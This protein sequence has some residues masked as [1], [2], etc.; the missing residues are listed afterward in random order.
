MVR[1]L[2]R[3]SQIPLVTMISYSLVCRVGV[4]EYIR[5]ASGAGVD[6]VIVPDLPV[7]E[8]GEVIREA[9]AKDLCTIFLAAPTT[10]PS[11]ARLVVENSTGFIYY[12]SVLGTTGIR[13]RLPGDLRQKI[14]ALKSQAAAVGRVA[15]GVIVGSAIVKK[16]SECAGRPQDELLRA[17]GGFVESLARGAKGR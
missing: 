6:G 5:R 15:D 7:E 9:R 12:I 17:V 1:R 2:R 16:I 10:T 14:A 4:P 11:R 3:E 8:A 13:D